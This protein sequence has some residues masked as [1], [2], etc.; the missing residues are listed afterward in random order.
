MSAT[1][2]RQKVGRPYRIVQI[3]QHWTIAHG[4][5]YRDCV[6]EYSDGR[7]ALLGVRDDLVSAAA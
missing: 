1:T 7:R 2:R 3:G 5:F 4:T 6:V